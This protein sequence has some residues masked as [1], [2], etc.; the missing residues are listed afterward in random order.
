V[1]LM[2]K[3]LDLLT[4]EEEQHHEVLVSPFVYSLCN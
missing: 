4:V 2:T 1:G 3:I